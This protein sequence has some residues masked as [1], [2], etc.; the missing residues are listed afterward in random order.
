MSIQQQMLNLAS[1]L[2]IKANPN[3][4]VI[5]YIP[6]GL[7]FFINVIQRGKG[8]DTLGRGGVHMPPWTF[9]FLSYYR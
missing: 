7:L 2:N 4:I 8:G 6:K 9:Y 3:Y 1:N 5:Y